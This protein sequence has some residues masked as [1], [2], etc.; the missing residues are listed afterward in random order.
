M[1][2]SR[3][4]DTLVVKSGQGNVTLVLTDSTTTK[5]DRGLFGLEKQQMADVVLEILFQQRRS[6]C[7]AS[8]SKRAMWVA[9]PQP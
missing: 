3:A 6:T 1:I 9:L 8:Y 5:D 7:A 4:G 2:I